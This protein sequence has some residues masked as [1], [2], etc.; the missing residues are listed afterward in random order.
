MGRLEMEMVKMAGVK[1]P[2]IRKAAKLW[3]TLV[4]EE[5]RLARVNHNLEIDPDHEN[6]RHRVAKI[7]VEERIEEIKAKLRSLGWRET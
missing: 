3:E 5:G 7:I 1:S 2:N 6:G 4:F